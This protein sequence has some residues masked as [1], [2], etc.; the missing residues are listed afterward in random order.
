MS[1]FLKDIDGEWVVR[2]DWHVDDVIGCG[3]DNGVALSD[4]EA[5]E[6]MQMIARGF[7]ANLGINWEV[8]EAYIDMF[9]GI[10]QA[11]KED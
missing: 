11:N 8:I 10:R 1:R 4:D 7:D 5:M 6:V 3:I 9:D 2:S